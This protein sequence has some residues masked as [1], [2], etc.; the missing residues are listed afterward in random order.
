[1][2]VSGS[3][4]GTHPGFTFS[5]STAS[6]KWTRRGEWLL[7]VVGH[8]HYDS[9]LDAWL[10]LHAIDGDIET[11]WR[12]ESRRG[13]RTDGHLC[14]GHV[15]SAPPE[16]KV[17]REKLFRFDEDIAAGWRHVDAK[18]V[19]MEAGHGGSEYCLMERLRPDGVDEEEWL[20]DG[21]K[22]LL[23]L[24]YFLVERG[25]DGQPVVTSRQPACTYKVSRYDGYFDAQAFWM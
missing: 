25:K 12:G 20:G 14:A 19:P 8:A 3:T 17:G 4:T 1:M 2:Y 5:F 9:E 16:W 21:D 18:L 23:R 11:P 10:G 15:A 24:T 22:S 6:G 7:P 13:L